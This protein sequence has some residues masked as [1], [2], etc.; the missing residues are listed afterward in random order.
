VLRGRRE[1]GAH[2]IAHL[3]PGEGEET[4]RILAQSALPCRVYGLRPGLT[5]D[6][7]DGDV[8]YRPFSE[9]RF[10]DD[11]RTARAVI[12]YGSFTLLSEAVY[13]GKPTLVV[14]S[15]GHFGHL[16]NALYLERL[17]YGAYAAELD[18]RTLA[19]FLERLPA[20]EQALA[21][22]AQDGNT[23]AI[24]AVRSVL[25]EATGSRRRTARSGR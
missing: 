25:A 12:A 23:A 13:L 9:D 7:A 10:V 17:G 11:L 5:E 16:L 8:L 3:P 14:P 20:F 6:V 21:G 19:A 1:A 24:A 4:A 15:R 22:Y 18:T 2:L